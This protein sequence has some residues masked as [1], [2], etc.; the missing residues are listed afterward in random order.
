M[1]DPSLITMLKLELYLKIKP[2]LEIESSM[3]RVLPLVLIHFCIAEAVLSSSSW[4]LAPV[5][6]NIALISNVI[7]K[8][9]LHENREILDCSVHVKAIFGYSFFVV[10]SSIFVLFEM[11]KYARCKSLQLHLAF[12][13]WIE[14]ETCMVEYNQFCSAITAV[15]IYGPWLLFI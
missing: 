1:G 14:F 11:M 12:R 7:Q 10:S 6:C 2:F 13:K 3:A 15:I 8:D 5:W 9:N 4:C